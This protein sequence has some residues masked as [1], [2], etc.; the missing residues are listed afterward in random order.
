LPSVLLL[1]AAGCGSAPAPTPAAPAVPDDVTV[2]AAAPA[3]DGPR[4]LLDRVDDGAIVQLRAAGFERLSLGEKLLAYHLSRAAIAGR[5]I[6]L[7]QRF[8][9]APPL[10]WILESLW[11]VRANLPADV[12]AE[13]ERYTKLFWVHSGIHD[14]T[15]TK[16]RLLR[17]SWEQFAAACGVAHD[18]GHRLASRAL[19]PLRDLREAWMLMTDPGCC[20][21]LCDKDA[22]DPLRASNN[23]LYAGVG[24]ADLAGFAEQ[25]A[26]NSRLVLR[27]GQLVEEVYRCGDGRQF[28]PGRYAEQLTVVNEHLRAALPFAPPAQRRSL[29]LLIRFHE[30]G[31]LADWQESQLAWLQDGGAAVDFRCGFVAGNLDPRGQKG[32]WQAVVGYRDEARTQALAELAA[33]LPWFAAHLPGDERFRPAAVPSPVPRAVQIVTATGAGDPLAPACRRIGFASTLVEFAASPAE[34]ARA[35]R[36]AAA[37]AELH[38]DLREI[39]GGAMA[40][41]PAAATDAGARRGACRAVLAAARADLAALYWIADAKLVELGRVPGPDAVLAAYEAYARTALEQLR[42][43]PAGGRLE[44]ADMQGRQLVVFWLLA[45]D[46]GVHFAHADGKT[47]YAVDTVPQFRQKCGE[48]LAELLRIEAE[49]DL[50]AGQ[51]LVDTFG[52]AVDPALHAEVLARAAPLDLPAVIG[53]VQPELRLVTDASGRPID[54]VVFHC[55]D[56]ADQM[57]RWSRRQ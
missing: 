11:L 45:N 18:C 38:S 42:L 57:L 3:A 4:H 22:A 19:A 52:T 33:L 27:D 2:A 55:Q 34:V 28:P 24:S 31:R 8:E 17:L 40:E 21:S 41:V 49:G 10:R 30:T 20:A 15:T 26:C 44:A 25:Y 6:F 36:H 56:L 39:L 29:A 13:V 23:N 53:F 46:G 9:H 37:M 48:L 54:V 47:H 14:G 7:D 35:E 50:A 16:K 1:F 32:A 12:R 51:A 5:D 43:L